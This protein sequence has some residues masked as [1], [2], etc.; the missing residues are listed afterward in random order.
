MLKSLLEEGQQIRLIGVEFDLLVNAHSLMANAT[1]SLIVESSSSTAVD[2]LGTITRESTADAISSSV[3]VQIYENEI[4]S[5]AA[6]NSSFISLVTVDEH[7]TSVTL[8]AQSIQTVHG[9]S[10]YFLIGVGLVLMVLLFCCQCIKRIYK[11]A[12]KK[13]QNLVGRMKLFFSRKVSLAYCQLSSKNPRLGVRRLSTNP[14]A[15]LVD[16]HLISLSDSSDNDDHLLDL[17][18]GKSVFTIDE[19]DESNLGRLSLCQLDRADGL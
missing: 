4:E 16:N 7:K 14:F 1:D 19:D 9:Y 2:Q 3:T 17:I 5:T 11:T 8:T 13:L 12:V 10:I 18:H 15:D 6:T